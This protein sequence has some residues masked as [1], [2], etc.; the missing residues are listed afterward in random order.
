MEASGKRWI[1]H[2]SRKDEFKIWNL[3]DLHMMSRAC[4]EGEIDKDIAQ[5]RDD[6]YS[7]WFGGGD[8]VEFIGATDK[9]F[10]PDCVAE[11]VSVK[12]LSR[13]GELGYKKIRDK[14]APIKHKCLGLLL[15][16]H[17]KHYCQHNE[18]ND[19]QTWLCTELG[20]PNLQY[21]ALADIV[22]VRTTCSGPKQVYKAPSSSNRA[23]ATFRFYLHHGAGFATT[24]GGKL[25]KLIQFMQSFEA[26][27][28]MC[29]HVH[30][31]VGRKEPTI[32]ANDDCTKLTAKEKVGVI[33]GSYLKT[34][35]QGV[36]TYG[37]QRGYRPVCLGAAWASINPETGKIRVE[38]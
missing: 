16:N 2:P 3:S 38:V 28:Y 31:K 17:E 26:D 11:W 18:Q 12:D 4:A 36:T 23:S 22:F 24:P 1:I 30:D 5:I 19:R 10:D 7:F 8:Y 9:R 27:V 32:G 29:G 35:A 25:N 34:Y 20:V 6:P 33:S 37:E 21:S 14:F 13:L 15:G